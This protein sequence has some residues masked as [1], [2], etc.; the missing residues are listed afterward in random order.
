MVFESL[1]VDLVNRYLGD[2]IENLDSSQLKIGI[3]GGLYSDISAAY[4][5]PTFSIMYQITGVG[6][7]IEASQ[8][9]LWVLNH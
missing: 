4:D 9:V 8:R 6:V 5:V 7:S 2:F 3:W 1:V